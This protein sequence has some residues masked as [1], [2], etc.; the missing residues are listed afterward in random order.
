MKSQPVSSVS[1]MYRYR[2]YLLSEYGNSDLCTC[3]IFL[4]FGGGELG[5]LVDCITS[6]SSLMSIMMRGV[7]HA[8]SATAVT[9]ERPRCMMGPMRAEVQCCRK[10]EAGR[11]DDDPNF[12][13]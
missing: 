13:G 11:Q 10:N 8:R 5:M 2:S 4:P 3:L 6:N 9:I 12:E 1:G 7:P